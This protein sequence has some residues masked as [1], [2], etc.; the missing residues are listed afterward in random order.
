VSPSLARSPALTQRQPQTKLTPGDTS[1]VPVT[2][3]PSSA[4]LLTVKNQTEVAYRIA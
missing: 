3:P 2:E 4:T 1:D